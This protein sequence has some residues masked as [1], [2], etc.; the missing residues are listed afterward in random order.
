M[1]AIIRNVPS[2][3]G[4]P[5]KRVHIATFHGTAMQAERDAD[6]G[7]LHVYHVSAENVPM[8]ALGDRTPTTDKSFFAEPNMTASKYQAGI[9]KW[10]EKHQDFWN[11]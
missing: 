1:N 2:H 9:E 3:D 4:M 11:K 8:N 10:R 7:D 6:T 5:A